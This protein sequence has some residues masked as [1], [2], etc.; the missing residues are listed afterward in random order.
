MTLGNVLTFISIIVA[1]FSFA[2]SSNRKVI[3]Y[4]FTKVDIS[5]GILSIISISYLLMFDF[6]EA[7]G[8]YIHALF[9]DNNKFPSPSEWA[10]IISIVSLLWLGFKSFLSRRIPLSNRRILF[11][12]YEDLIH[13]NIPL[14]VD[15]LRTYHSKEIKKKIE[16]LNEYNKE[17]ENERDDLSEFHLSDKREEIL[18]PSTFEI[19]FNSEFIQGIV[20]KKYEIYYLSIISK[21]RNEKVGGFKDAVEFFYRTM[22]RESDNVLTDAIEN[23]NNELDD[24]DYPHIAYRLY[25]YKFSELTFS[26]LNFTINLEVWRSFGEEGIRSAETDDLFQ[27]QNNEWLSERF[28]SS[29]AYLCLRFYDILI[30]QIIYDSLKYT[31]KY[32]SSSYIY[33]YYLF[34]VCEGTLKN[35]YKTGYT[36]SF[37]ERLVG[38]T[39]NVIYLL[40]EIQVRN[41]VELYITSLTRILTSLIETKYLPEEKRISLAKWFLEKYLDLTIQTGDKDIFDCIDK[42]FKEIIIRCKSTMEKGYSIIDKSKYT[43]YNNYDYIKSIFE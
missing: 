37:A 13:E 4:K 42:P 29:P 14:L 39:I 8:L 24:D 30:R 6:I 23:T 17:N 9:I 10:Y 40:L 15:Y 21:L 34:L 3:F 33:D 32:K 35:T 20:S 41:S 27:K 43:N 12:Y 38:D 31:D 25:E 5:I 28:L 16:R 22:L 11:D 26:D 36:G 2:F 7:N 18:L 1:M 19:L